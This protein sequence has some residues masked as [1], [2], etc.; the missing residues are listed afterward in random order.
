MQELLLKEVSNH[1]E[2]QWKEN[3]TLP[4]DDALQ[5]AYKSYDAL[6]FTK[7]HERIL[8]ENYQKVNKAIWK[9]VLSYFTTTKTLVPIATFSIPYFLIEQHDVFK[10]ALLVYIILF[11]IAMIIY[12][13]IINRKIKKQQKLSQKAFSYET[14]ATQLFQATWILL[15]PIIPQFISQIDKRK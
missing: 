8:E 10:I 3:P 9:E 13:F 12:S 15:L 6:G 7:V 4:F 2:N 14:T 1:I 11:Y 5:N